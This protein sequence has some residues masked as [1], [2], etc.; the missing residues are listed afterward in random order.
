MDWI[1]RDVTRMKVINKLKCIIVELIW[2]IMY[3]T[4]EKAIEPNKNNMKKLNRKKVLAG[5]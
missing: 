4:P 2:K 5:G 1:Y 3:K